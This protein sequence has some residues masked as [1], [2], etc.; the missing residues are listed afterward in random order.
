MH[1]MSSRQVRGLLFCMLAAPA[2]LLG[3]GPT[4]GS[5]A[6]TV[7]NGMTGAPLRRAVIVLSTVEPKPQDARAWTDAEGRFSFHF[8]PPG[9]YQINASKDGFQGAAFGSDSRNRLPAIVTLGPGESRTDINFRLGFFG[10]ISGVI[11]DEAG[12]PVANAHVQA[13]RTVFQRQRRTLVP[14]GG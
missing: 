5:I 3:Q 11:L 7:T 13:L 4:T 2:C 10:I 9:R 8:L 6:G 12:D 1:L 14:G